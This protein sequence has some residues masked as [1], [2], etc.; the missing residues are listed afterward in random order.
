MAMTMAMLPAVWDTTAKQSTV[1]RIDRTRRRRSW[2]TR[3]SA[4]D[5]PSRGGWSKK[6]TQSTYLFFLHAVSQVWPGTVSEWP[7]CACLSTADVVTN[8]WMNGCTAAY[9]VGVL[10]PCNYIVVIYIYRRNCI[11]SRCEQEQ[12][13]VV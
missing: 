4:G 9:R 3:R 8:E 12:V 1:H 7:P 2:P 11:Y 13:E 6:N 10:P 5:R